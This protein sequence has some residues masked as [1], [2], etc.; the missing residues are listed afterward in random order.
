MTFKIGQ[1]VKLVGFPF[2]YG[3]FHDMGYEGMEAEL[4]RQDEDGDWVVKHKGISQVVPFDHIQP[5]KEKHKFAVGDKVIF[6]KPTEASHFHLLRGLVGTFDIIMVDPVDNTA[7]LYKD[8]ERLGWAKFFEIKPAP[9]D[10]T[11]PEVSAKDKPKVAIGAVVRTLANW[12]DVPKGSIGVLDSHDDYTPS[13]VTLWAVKTAGRLTNEW[14]LPRELE[15]LR[16]AERKRKFSVG[17]RV[18]VITEDHGQRQLGA[19]GTITTTERHGEF[20]YGV[21]YADGHE[22]Y[23]ATNVYREGDLEILEYA[24]GI[25]SEPTVAAVPEVTPEVTPAAPVVSEKPE[26]AVGDKVVFGVPRKDREILTFFE[27]DDAVFTVS[28]T[29]YR[30]G[31]LILIDPTTDKT[32]VVDNRD[33]KHAPT[34]S[35]PAVIPSFTGDDLEETI[36]TL[37]EQLLRRLL[38]KTDVSVTVE[39]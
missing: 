10:L 32:Q 20:A 21:A 6:R 24:E 2:D 12:Q 16:S 19:I 13:D 17:D 23:Q 34:P 22:Q 9:V 8:G 37:L 1:T 4:V 15:V 18:K 31:T 7:L 27:D 5:L 26:F 3:A 33:I 25:S 11:T 29:G 35:L 36:E 28:R 14:Y 39:I 30:A 38:G